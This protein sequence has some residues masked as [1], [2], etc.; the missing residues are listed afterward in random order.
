MK[1]KNVK[2]KSELQQEQNYELH[3]FLTEMIEEWEWDM[4]QA[5]LELS[6]F[7]EEGL[8]SVLCGNQHW[9]KTALQTMVKSSLQC[10]KEGTVTFAVR[11]EQTEL[12]DYMLN[13]SI[14]DHGAG[15]SEEA[16]A[17]V[18]TRP[19][20]KETS[21][22]LNF[23]DIKKQAELSGG[24]FLLRSV[25]GD[26]AFYFLSLPQGVIDETPMEKLG[27][28]E[29]EE[30]LFET[31]TEA[32]E[33]TETEAEAGYFSGEE[34]PG[35]KELEEKEP[36]EKEP[37]EKAEVEQE[38][39]PWIDMEI[40]M[41]Y[42][43]GM[44]E[45]RQEML[46][47]YYEQAL[48][49]L[50]ELPEI[51]KNEDWEQ[52]R[53]VVHAIKGN[54]LGIGAKGFSEEAFEHEKA[55]RDGEI[56]KIKENWQSFYNHYLS[57]IAEVCG[58]WKNYFTEVEEKREIMPLNSFLAEMEELLGIVRNYEMAEALERIERL[59]KLDIEGED[60]EKM[61]ALWNRVKTAVDGLDFDTGEAGVQDWL[62][63][64]KPEAVENEE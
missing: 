59:E 51:Y 56:H 11:G 5:G 62:A 34:K 50:K 31:L 25:A 43:G 53:I 9:I 44:E 13:L 27:R 63:K 57:L 24:R 23:Y 41:N 4:E 28:W 33:E 61:T 10:T 15:F 35:E 64:H 54:S 17:D 7:A 52:Y 47:I 30:P 29:E 12:G 45:M 20:G 14:A 39:K 18:F 58:Q 2:K 8:P 48:K 3:S 38:N 60:R 42:C 16:L 46:G 1:K 32:A 55:A 6:V 49:Y 40:A 22:F 21:P 19:V 37:E 36:E 26:G